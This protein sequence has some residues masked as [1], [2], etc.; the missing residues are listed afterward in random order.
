MAETRLTLRR[1]VPDG[2]RLAW[3]RPIAAATGDRVPRSEA[4][5]YDR[6]DLYH[7]DT[8]EPDLKLQAVRVGDPGLAARPTRFM[9]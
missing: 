9:R 7:R 5:V 6:E 3:A 2:S 4:E 8:P 1:R